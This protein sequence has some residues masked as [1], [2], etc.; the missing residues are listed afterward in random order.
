MFLRVDSKSGEECRSV[1]GLCYDNKKKK[2]NKTAPSQFNY[3]AHEYCNLRL[4][5]TIVSRR[6]ASPF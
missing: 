1:S 4:K 5:V 3:F 2:Q 6:I